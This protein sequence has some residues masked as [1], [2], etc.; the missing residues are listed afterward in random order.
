M[1]NS[2]S[3]YA[4]GG[5]IIYMVEGKENYI[6]NWSKQLQYVTKTLDL[7]GGNWEIIYREH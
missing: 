1:G 6:S 3:A 5:W 2:L 7:I 4:W